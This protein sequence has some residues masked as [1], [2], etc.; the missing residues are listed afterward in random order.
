[1][2]A[3][4]A[5]TAAAG[6]QPDGGRAAPDRA[7]VTVTAPPPPAVTPARAA[8]PTDTVSAERR[9][10]A[11]AAAARER[12]VRRARADRRERGARLR[13]RATAARR[14]P[15]TVLGSV[16]RARVRGHIGAAEARTYAARY[17]RARSA[18]G[19]L[20]GERAAELRA[21]VASAERLA[22]G[23]RL[24]AG[25]IPAVFL[26]LVRNERFWS[27]RGPPAAGR[28]F[29]FGRDPVILQYYPGQGLRLQPL[30][31]AAEAN[32][33]Y[34]ACRGYNTRPGTPCRKRTLARLLDRLVELGAR[35]GGFTAWEYHFSFAGGSAPWISGMAQGTVIQALARGHRFLGGDDGY[36]DA[37]REGLG[38]FEAPAPVGV[39]VPAPGGTHYAMYSQDPRLKVLNGFLQAIAGIQTYARVSDE[40]RAWRLFRAGDGAARRAVPAF[41]TGGWS[42]Y[43]QPGGE[44]TVE[45]HRLVRDFLGNLCRRD[46]GSVYCRTER[47]FTR[48]LEDPPGL[49][50]RP[51]RGARAG[52][53]LR[54]RF[55]L[56][57]SA[58]VTVR[59]RSAG[60]RTVFR[61]RLRLQRGRH[62]VPWTPHS[63]RS[64]RVSVSAN[65][66]RGLRSKRERVARVRQR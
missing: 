29:T 53:P 63:G 64:Y 45:Y 58:V 28:R 3:V 31:S 18:L 62:E 2:A 39:A 43:S 1:M 22:A 48:Y 14:T 44:S 36:L 16:R 25:R 57:R 34:N 26:E 41:D 59:A 13:A 37:A 38:A 55:R 10:R 56:S 66:A 35:R 27:R 65:G 30:A 23:G 19:R 20:D 9:E 47:R 54:V 50:V 61:R 4:T 42:L 46:G 60:D 24:S 21:V 6:E 40:R 32:R 33:L 7:P 17:R 51:I 12:R 11:A 52:R 15:R 49:H 8:R 5:V